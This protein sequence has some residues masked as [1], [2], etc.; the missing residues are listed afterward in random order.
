MRRATG[1]EI[2]A[3]ADHR[4]VELAARAALQLRHRLVR[5]A[6]QLGNPARVAQQFPAGRR[7]L[8]L[9]ADTLEERQPGVALQRLDLRR[10]RG[11]RQVQV[12]RRPRKAHPVGNRSE[13]RELA[14]RCVTHPQS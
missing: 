3:R 13:D 7:E 11:L 5:L 14:Q 9:A 1:E 2:I 6:E 8:Q 4:D 12:F 10:Y